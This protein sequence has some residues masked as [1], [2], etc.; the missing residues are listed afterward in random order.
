MAIK[1]GIAGEYRV[2]LKRAD[3]SVRIDTGVQKNLILNN[4]LASMTRHDVTKSNGETAS[5]SYPL[6][7]YCLIGTGNTAPAET[8]TALASFLAV[9]NSSS[10]S[11]D[12]L[13]TSEEM[14]NKGYI[15]YSSSVKYQF[16]G[17]HGNN[18]T[19]IGLGR[20]VSD[21]VYILYTRALILDAQGSPLT[22]SGG[23]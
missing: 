19:E 7:G 20:Y 10:S 11:D 13:D 18:I 16:S 4:L 14:R 21:A 22:I 23:R 17:V 3:G 2:V 15:K 1:S 5:Y 6:M 9:N 12:S 8:D